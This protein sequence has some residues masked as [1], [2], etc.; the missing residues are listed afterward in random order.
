MQDLNEEKDRELSTLRQNMSALQLDSQK[1]ISDLESQ[2]TDALSSAAAA[3]AAAAG[4][5]SLY[6]LVVC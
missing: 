3:A 6:R 5:C 4:E 2:L 1:R